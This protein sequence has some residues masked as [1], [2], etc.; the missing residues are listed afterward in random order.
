MQTDT[1]HEVSV[2]IEL[3][4]ESHSYTALPLHAW[5]PGVQVSGKHLPSLQ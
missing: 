1:S 3:P 2:T 5:M 4:V